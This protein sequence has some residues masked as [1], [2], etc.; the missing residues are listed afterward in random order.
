MQS[1][2]AFRAEILIPEKR[3]LVLAVEGTLD[4]STAA[5]FKE[6]LFQSIGQGARQV[7]VDLTKMSSLDSTGLGVLVSGVKRAAKGSCCL[8]CP[9]EA[10]TAIFAMVGIDRLVTVFAS[11]RAALASAAA[12]TG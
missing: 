6:L 1:D 7:I 4:I 12:A 3:V 10:V 5:H 2:P 8:V 9:D 11:R